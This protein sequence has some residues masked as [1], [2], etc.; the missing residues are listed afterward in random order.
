LSLFLRGARTLWRELEDESRE[1][2]VAW[3]ETADR[4][5]K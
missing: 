4:I 2:L 5:Q 3:F 1:D